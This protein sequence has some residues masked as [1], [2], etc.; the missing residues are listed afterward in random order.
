MAYSTSLAKLHA[1]G[2]SETSKNYEKSHQKTAAAQTVSRN[3]V[4]M[5]PM[6]LQTP[7]SYSTSYTL[8]VNLDS[9]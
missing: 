8:W 9:L 6:S 3:M 5:A 4:E 2:G 7:T 1:Q